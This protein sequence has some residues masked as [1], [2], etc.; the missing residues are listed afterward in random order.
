MRLYGTLKGLKVLAV[1]AFLSQLGGTSIQ[2]LT[3]LRQPH[4]YALWKILV[5]TR[6]SSADPL[7][8]FFLLLAQSIL[9]MFALSSGLK[10]DVRGCVGGGWEGGEGV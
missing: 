2:V 10:G 5:W 3:I 1:R 6:N 7:G 4:G 9:D 8:A